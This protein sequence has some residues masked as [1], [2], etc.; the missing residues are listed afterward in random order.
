MAI[1]QIE[2]L[3]TQSEA[4]VFSKTYE[5]ISSLL[6]VDARLILWGKVDKRDDQNQFIV[7]DAEPVEK[8]QM[9]MVELNPEQGSHY[10][11][12]ESS[13]GDFKRIFLGR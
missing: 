13:L 8:V 9:V 10:G 7:D 4:V 11:R 1:L 2:D 3:T 6:E 5:R 12:T